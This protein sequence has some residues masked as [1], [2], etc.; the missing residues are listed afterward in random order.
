MLIFAEE[1]KSGNKNPNLIYGRRKKGEREERRE[2]GKMN[3]WMDRRRKGK[4]EGRKE[5]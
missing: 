4:M 3:G 5:G 2:E 1:G